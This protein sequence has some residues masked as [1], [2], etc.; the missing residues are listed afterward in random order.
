MTTKRK[1]KKPAL[2]VFELKQ[3]PQLLAGSALRD[4]YEPT[5]WPES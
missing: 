3:M 2:Q 4:P 5:E 1:Y